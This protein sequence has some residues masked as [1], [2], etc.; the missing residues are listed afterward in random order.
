MTSVA[1]TDCPI[2]PVTPE[3]VLD[4]V[5]RITAQRSE[6]HLARCLVDTLAAMGAFAAVRI[7]RAVETGGQRYLVTLASTQ[8]VPPD[9]AEE[10]LLPLERDPLVAAAWACGAAAEAVD[11]VSRRHRRAVPIPTG[12]GG[13]Q[14]FLVV[15]GAHALE[16]CAPV[17][18]GFVAIYRNYADLLGD[19]ARDTLTGLQNRKTFDEGISRVIAAAARLLSGRPAA[20]RRHFPGPDDYHWL[21]ILDI[22]HFKRVNDEFGHVFGDEVLLLFAQIMR[23]AFRAVDQLYRYGG[24]EFVVVL[25]PTSFDSA[26]HV[27]E[28]FRHAVEEHDFPQVGRV[29][30]SVG[31]IRILPEDIPAS[32]VGHADQA[33]YHAKRHGRN[34]VCS[35][36]MLV[37]QGLL[38]PEHTEGQAE[39]FG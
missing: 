4:W 7:D 26:R 20:D 25:E 34:Q 14:G 10:D 36:E 13:M 16:A 27:F 22:D 19:A 30:C 2:R 15:E 8:V 11:P 29:T 24:E 1:V 37:R 39:L 12:S 5:V 32:V 6:G 35:Y 23:R 38:I 17:L 33:L 28:R 18:D 3:A 9:M 21:G 31:F